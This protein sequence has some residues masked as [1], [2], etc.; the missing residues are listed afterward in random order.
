MATNI[1]D[2]EDIFSIIPY[3]IYIIYIICVCIEIK[4]L[5]RNKIS[6]FYKENFLLVLIISANLP[7]AL[8]ALGFGCYA[9]KEITWIDDGSDFILCYYFTF[10]AAALG[11]ITHYIKTKIY[12]FIRPENKLIFFETGTI[13]DKEENQNK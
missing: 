6:I 4:L 7:V 3:N 5:K 10:V 13:Y 1:R 12:A 11:Y 8:S 9:I 2:I